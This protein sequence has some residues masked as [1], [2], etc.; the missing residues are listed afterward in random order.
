MLQTVGGAS[1]E[2]AG[3]RA[4]VLAPAVIAGRCSHAMGGPM[5]DSGRHEIT[6]PRDLAGELHRHMQAGSWSRLGGDDAEPPL[7]PIAS[8]Q[9][10]YLQ[11]IR[12]LPSE[13]VV[14]RM[15]DVTY[16]ASLLEEEGRRIEC[17]CG[18]LSAEGVGALGF[19]AYRFAEPLP[20]IPSM[21]AKLAPALQP[22]RTEIGVWEHDGQLV[23]WGLIHH[24]DRNFAIDLD[25]TPPYFATHLLRP[26]AFTVHYDER[27]LLLFSRDHGQFFVRSRDLLGVIRDRG[28][29]DPDGAAALCR[30]A[31]RMLRHG[32]GGTILVAPKDAPR[33]GL[34]QHP[35]LSAADAPD[36]ILA[37]AMR[38]DARAM[39]GEVREYSEP[40]AQYVE[41][42]MRIE[43]A[44]AEAL[45]F[46]A[47]LTAVD[48]AVV[49]DSELGLYGAGATILMP[50]SAMP[51]EVVLEDPRAPDVRER[52]PLAAL[53]GNR[54]RSAVAF[55]AQQRGPALALVAS[56]DGDLSLFV[57]GEDGLV[58]AIRPFELGVG[59]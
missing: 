33:T 6:F 48:G 26:G 11:R 39:R 19:G 22:G 25:H 14:A 59:L 21:L 38:L 3:V 30:L 53:G 52:V 37:D 50:D 2:L 41:R 44:H 36:R 31:Q 9:R 32:H 49:L 51:T 8:E 35:A 34:V 18:F 28:A 29:I 23:V 24:G 46:V 15:L 17:S 40:L 1:G 16:V 7:S 13:P 20:F 55:C 54:H 56:Q 4:S 12:P 5:S 58:H 57:R 47:Y 43:K 45:D 27:L 42:R 10:A